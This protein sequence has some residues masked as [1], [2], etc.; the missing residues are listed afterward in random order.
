MSDDPKQVVSR[1]VEQMFNCHD[2]AAADRYVAADCVD[3][4]GFP[5]QAP[6]LAGMKARWGMLLV[7][8]PDFCITI[9][10]LIAE[11]DK[12]SMRATGRGTHRG[13]FFGVPATDT[14]VSF[15]EINLSRIVDGHMVEHWA[16]R[17]T[18]EVLQQIGAI[19]G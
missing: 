7:A 19:P 15:T 5:G 13:E 17:S 14:S 18:F 8:F 9:E 4:S 11:G 3:H 2:L 1:I 16:E 10:D 12:V 6:G